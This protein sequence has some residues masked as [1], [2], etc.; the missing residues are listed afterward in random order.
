MTSGALRD[1]QSRRNWN[2]HLST[3]RTLFLS[4]PNS[5]FAYLDCG[6]S[7][8]DGHALSVLTADSNPGVERQIVAHGCDMF[9]RLRSAAA[10][11]RTLHRCCNISIFN[12]VCLGGGKG[13]LPARNIYLTAAKLDRIQSS[14]YRANDVFPGVRAR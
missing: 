14:L 1:A 13:K 9:K 7:D 12:Q 3:L 8:T 5:H 6:D 2:P 11:R 10:Q 4:A